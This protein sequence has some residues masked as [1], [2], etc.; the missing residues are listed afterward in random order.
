[1]QRD[2]YSP[3]LC[4]SG[5]KFKW[6]CAPIDEQVQKAYVQ[7]RNKQHEAALGILQNLTREHP[8]NAAVWCYYAEMLLNQEKLE[9]AGLAIDQALAVDSKQ[10]RALYLKGI[11]KQ[12]ANDLQTA[13]DYYRQAA[14]V[15]DPAATL[16]MADIHLGISQC[17]TLQNRPI[18]AKAALDIA[19]RCEPAS[20][21]IQ[22]RLNHFFGVESEYPSVVRKNHAFKKMIKKD[23]LPIDVQQA[24]QG[25]KLGKLHQ[26]ME[27][28][29]QQLSYDPA[30][31]YNLGLTRAW[32][33]DNQGA[34]EALDQYVRQA[35]QDQEAAEAWC[36]AE[37]LSMGSPSDTE[38]D[39]T[40]FFR[41]YRIVDFR[42]FVELLG[43]DKQIV[44]VEQKNPII[45]CRRLDRPLPA[46]SETL[47]T[48]EL[49]R[50]QVRI[51]IM[52]GEVW[53]Y[54]HD[55]KRVETARAELEASWGDSV[56]FTRS[57]TQ[58]ASFPHLVDQVLDFRVPE[59][60]TTEQVQRLSNE[61]FRSYFEDQWAHRPFRVLQ[62]N[63]PI[64]AVGH[65]VLRRKLQGMILLL[66]QVLANQKVPITYTMDDLRRK[67]G[68][69]DGPIIQ[70][71]EQSA[72]PAVIASLSAAEL[73]ALDV[74]L[75]S[76]DDLKQAFATA[77]RLDA[78]EIAGKFAQALVAKVGN[79]PGA[80]CFIYDQHVIFQLLGEDRIERAYATT[81]KMLDRDAKLNAGKRSIDY[82]KLRLK[83]LLAGK[84]LGEAKIELDKLLSER[85]DD[86][87][88]LGFAVE[89]LLKFGHKDQAA[90]YAKSGKLLAAK[91]NDR[92]RLG[93]FEDIQKRFG[94]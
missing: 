54:S 39:H 61:M 11:I 90:H 86:L 19:H 9:D 66:E 40:L 47:A 5:K 2:P 51:M 20:Q 37:A 21:V 82:R 3:C 32:V 35:N 74:A 25:G 10:P 34:I 52:P 56:Q 45:L 69:A 28:L 62:G 30:F 81:I 15:C 14:D 16:V 49:P 76:E 27:K 31:F 36:L 70:T 93:Y 23:A 17:E 29:V 64:D 75:L 41:A 68:L 67:L 89:E 59:G 94:S 72:A 43:A 13:L 55:P 50:I 42:R 38:K 87:D 12:T 78:N 7:E 24:T 53:I 92:D 84:R 18:A 48:F 85:A 77:K 63:T 4:G 79:S 73:A 65:P 26:L 88:L 1:M 33:G 6:C 57:F 46:A 71:H 44:E 60:L 80:D 22:E 8:K 58:A 83:V 91:K